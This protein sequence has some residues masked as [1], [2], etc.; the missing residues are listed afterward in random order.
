MDRNKKGSVVLTVVIAAV[1]IGFLLFLGI[2]SANNQTGQTTMVPIPTI[3]AQISPVPVQNTVVT[4][5]SLDGD[6]QDLDT[7]I[8]GLDAYQNNINA[9]VNDKPIDTG[10]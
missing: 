2:K 9:A 1:V 6:L 3:E 5:G 10:L 7:K 8:S 4:T